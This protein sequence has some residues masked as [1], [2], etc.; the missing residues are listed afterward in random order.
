[1][2]YPRR[3]VGSSMLPTLRDGQIVIVR[4]TRNFTVG[5]VVTAYVSGKDVIKRITKIKDGKVYLE[6]DNL[7][8]STDSRSFGWLSD[9]YIEG[10]V[11]YPRISKKKNNDLK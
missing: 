6:G 1:M 3:V 11:V 9:Q 2:F 5:D 4:L 7:K 8:H 10:K